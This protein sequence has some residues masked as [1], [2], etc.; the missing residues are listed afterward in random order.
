MNDIRDRGRLLTETFKR[1]DLM[2]IT[3]AEDIIYELAQEIE[4]Y[5]DTIE[6]M[7]AQ[8]STKQINIAISPDSIPED[9]RKRIASMYIGADGSVSLYF[10]NYFAGMPVSPTLD[11]T[12][13]CNEARRDDIG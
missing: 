2:G 8:D 1:M 10:E 13:Y 5:R 12:I 3:N 9:M 11:D 4:G 7:K 6:Q